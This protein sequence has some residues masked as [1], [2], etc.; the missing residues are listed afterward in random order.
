MQ[1]SI[2]WRNFLRAEQGLPLRKHYANDAGNA[3]RLIEK[4]T[5]GPFGDK[6]YQLRPT[7]RGILNRIINSKK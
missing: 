4:G 6:Q 7:T 5:K 2:R 3:T 1:T